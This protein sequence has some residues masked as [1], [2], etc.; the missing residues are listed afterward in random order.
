MFP[1]FKT[2]KEAFEEEIEYNEE[3]HKLTDENLDAATLEHF[4]KYLFKKALEVKFFCIFYG[5]MCEELINLELNLRD[6][7]QSR[8]NLKHSKFRK[9]LFN[10]CKDCFEK[11]F[12]AD[13]KEK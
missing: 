3:E 13:E 4:V 8:A 6:M 1:D 5:Q 7:E 10:V 11:F 2:K 9:N 12:D